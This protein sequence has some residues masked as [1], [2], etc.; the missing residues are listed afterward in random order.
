MQYRIASAACLLAL[1]GCDGEVFAMRRPEPCVSLTS[2]PDRAGAANSETVTGALRTNGGGV[3]VVLTAPPSAEA[4]TTLASAGLTPPDGRE[5]IV[6]FATLLPTTVWG[7]IQPDGVRALVG[8]CFVARVEPSA[9]GGP[10]G[11]Q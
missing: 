8:L 9:L 5:A 11:P 10:V 1:A 4:L 2:M 6:H 3:F 7:A